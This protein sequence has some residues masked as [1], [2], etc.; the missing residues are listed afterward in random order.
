M[1]YKKMWNDL[2]E[3][4]IRVIETKDQPGEIGFGILYANEI[5]MYMAKAEVEESKKYAEVE[6][7]IDL[8]LAKLLKG[9][10]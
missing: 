5:L 9:E 4:M 2:K 1:N 8:T 6:R 3:E 7:D 10:K